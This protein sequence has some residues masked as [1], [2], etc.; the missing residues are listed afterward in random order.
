MRQ[1]RLMIAAA[2]LV[3]IVLLSLCLGKYP[4]GIAD[5][6]QFM[7]DRLLGM[8]AMDADK[9][10]IIGNLILDIRLPR[11]FAAA[12]IGASLSVSGAAYQSLFINPLVSPGLLG[13]LAGASFGAVAGMVFSSSWIVVE[14]STVVFGFAAVGVAAGISR[15]YRSSS[16]IMLVLG[17]I[18]SG[19]FFTS[20]VSIVKYLSD[21]A[22]QLPAIVFWL[23]GN[24]TMVDRHTML[25]V[26]IPLVI[27][28]LGLTLYGRHLN[29]LSMGEEE[30]KALGVNVRL[31]RAG[32]IFFA[33][34]ISSLTVMVAGMIGWVGLII[35]HIA[36]MIVGPD[37]SRL[38][39]A[40][41]FIGAAYLVMADDISRLVFSY[42]IPI[43]IITSIVGIPFFAL[44]LH[45]AG[46]EWS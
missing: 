30:A 35:P 1:V 6:L 24:L 29:V 4:V 2:A 13:V 46:K 45:K 7:G 10:A 19:A 5:L 8:K 20:L 3:I 23:M 34:L 17:G 37:N 16:L 40:S 12:L 41:A 11:V 9:A 31:I 14:I 42:E 27:G 36:R 33:T 32:V 18:V 38:L 39:P 44:V 26:S 28:I 22:N 25:V 21:P 43:G 15:I